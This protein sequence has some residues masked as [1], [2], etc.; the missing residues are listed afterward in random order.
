[1]TIVSGNSSLGGAK[2]IGKLGY[3]AGLQA[4]F[5]LTENFNIESGVLYTRMGFQL[6]KKG[7]DP[8]SSDPDVAQAFS[9]DYNFNFIQVPLKIT[10]H[11]KGKFRFIASAGF[12]V[13]FE[14]DLNKELSVYYP[15]R[16]ETE[17]SSY[18]TVNSAYLFYMIGAGVEYQR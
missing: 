14:S 8:A 15:E 9:E 2:E 12:A 1:R 17:K 3:S 4:V 13:N 6:K 5:E 18:S 7:L 11:T 10:F 16:T